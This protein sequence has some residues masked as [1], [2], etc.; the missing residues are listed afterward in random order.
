MNIQKFNYNNVLLND[1]SVTN[2]PTIITGNTPITDD[3]HID[4]GDL[5]INGVDIGYVIGLDVNS[6]PSNLNVAELGEAINSNA[7]PLLDNVVC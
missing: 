6:N 3:N 2:T 4:A 5:L 1:P 7:D